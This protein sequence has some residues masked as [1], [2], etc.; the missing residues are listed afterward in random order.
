M[1]KPPR[2]GCEWALIKPVGALQLQRALPVELPNREGVAPKA[3]LLLEGPGV[4]LER[5]KFGVEEE[6]LL[7]AAAAKL[8]NVAGALDVVPKTKGFASVKGL[9]VVAVEEEG[10][11]G[12]AIEELPPLGEPNTNGIVEE[13]DVAVVVVR[14]DVFPKKL[15]T[16]VVVVAV[17]EEAPATT[18]GDSVA[19]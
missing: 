11:E 6:G 14:L 18:L 7:L 19:D 5:M 4:T 8:P 13:N 3:A 9:L 15:L 17:V 16:V 1:G 10:T 2:P 12:E